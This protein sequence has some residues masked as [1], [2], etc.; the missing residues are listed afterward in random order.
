MV[1]ILGLKHQYVNV[2]I[3]VW[4]EKYPFRSETEPMNRSYKT[5]N[6]REQMRS[7]TQ[8][9]IIITQRETENKK[10]TNENKIK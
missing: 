8:I 6:V 1:L 10:T 3:G 2:P 5:T 7:Q 9:H 4:Q